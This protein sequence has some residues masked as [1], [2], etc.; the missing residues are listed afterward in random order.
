MKREKGG[1]EQGR[2]ERAREKGNEQ[3]TG[4]GASITPSLDTRYGQEGVAVSC[5]SR[6]RCYH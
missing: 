5:V 1:N 3:G 6:M 2:R 4:G